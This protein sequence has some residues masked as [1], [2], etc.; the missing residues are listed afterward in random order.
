[1][2]STSDEIEDGPTQH[3]DLEPRANV[4]YD[5]IWAYLSVSCSSHYNLNGRSG[6]NLKILI[7][8]YMSRVLGGLAGKVRVFENWVKGHRSFGIVCNRSRSLVVIG[9][10]WDLI[11]CIFGF[12]LDFGI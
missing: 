12:I 11:Y 8:E 1:M 3:S 2:I 10:H 5:S 7:K 9:S 6:F 4:V